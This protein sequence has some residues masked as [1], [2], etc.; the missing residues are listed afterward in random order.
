MLL[1]DNQ[2]YIWYKLTR[3]T[4]KAGKCN[5]FAS[6][7]SDA[8]ATGVYSESVE[9]LTSISV[10][11]WACKEEAFKLYKEALIESALKEGY[12]VHR[13]FAIPRKE[14]KVLLN[15]SLKKTIELDEQFYS[16]PYEPKR[17]TKK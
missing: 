4:G 11:A 9:H 7:K 8:L 17:T 1:W 14:Y 3:V 5:T 16:L 12:T 10:N 6:M 13:V 2:V 15:E